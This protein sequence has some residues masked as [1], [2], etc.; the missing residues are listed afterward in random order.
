MVTGMRRREEG[1]YLA[2]Q[3]KQVVVVVF[4]ILGAF[5]HKWI[6]T[7][8]F[9]FFIFGIDWEV[10]S[11]RGTSAPASSTHCAPLSQHS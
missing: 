6:F 1:K 4:T 7:A 2:K 10:L 8:G 9:S 5:S 3:N 11:A